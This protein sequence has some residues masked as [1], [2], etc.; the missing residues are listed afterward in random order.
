MHVNHNQGTEDLALQRAELPP[1]FVDNL[2]AHHK[3]FI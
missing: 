3:Y 1:D 2:Q